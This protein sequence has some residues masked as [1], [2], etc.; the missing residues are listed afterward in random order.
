MNIRTLRDVVVLDQV[1]VLEERGGRLMENQLEVENI[2][3][4]VGSVLSV[5]MYGVHVY[6]RGRLTVDVE[7]SKKGFK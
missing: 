3:I 4:S 5:P 1:S 7:L 6:L 2:D